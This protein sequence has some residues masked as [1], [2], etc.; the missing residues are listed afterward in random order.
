MTRIPTASA[1]RMKSRLNQWAGESGLVV[2]MHLELGTRSL[3]MSI[4][5]NVCGIRVASST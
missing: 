5:Q 1:R 2:A 4:I 3:D